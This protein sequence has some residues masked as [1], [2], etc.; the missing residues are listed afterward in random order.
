MKNRRVIKVLH[1]TVLT[2]QLARSWFQIPLTK[3]DDKS[4]KRVIYL[5]FIPGRFRSLCKRVPPSL[6]TVI[7]VTLDLP[8]VFILPP[9]DRT[10]IVI[11]L[12][13]ALGLRL[14]LPLSFFF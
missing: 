3:T 6:T 7:R 14:L 10:I 1:S 9:D 5:A 2:Q 4:F 11:L 12:S 13:S 8:R